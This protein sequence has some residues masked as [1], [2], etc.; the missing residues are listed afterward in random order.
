MATLASLVVKLIT[1]AGGFNKGLGEAE[2][3][4][5]SFTGGIQKNLKSIGTLA[6][7]AGGLIAA[8]LGG[9]LVTL[10]PQA[11]NAASDFQESLSKVQV[12]FGDSGAAVE[13]FSR[14]TAASMGI[15]QRDALAAAGTFGNLFRT[16]DIGEGASAQMSMDLVGL[17]ADLASFNNLDPTEVLDKLRSGLVGETEPLRSLGINLTDA[18][19]R[20]KAMELGLASSTK[21]VSQAA[22]TQARFALIMDQSALAQ[23][24]FARTS[25]GLANQQ[26]ILGATWQDILQKVGQV[27]LPLLNGALGG[28]LTLLQGS[29]IPAIDRVVQ[30]FTDFQWMLSVGVEPLSAFGM[31]LENLGVP[32]EVV[33]GIQGFVTG[34]QTL[35]T[36]VITAA[37]PI[38]AWIGQN[39]QLQDV[40]IAIGAAIAS[41][42]VPAIASIIAA[43]APVVATFVG[44]VAI[45]A[46]LRAAWESDFL[47]IQTALTAAWAVIQ[48]AL[49]ELWTW[50]QTNIPVALQTLS[51]FWTGTLLPAI[52]AVWDFLSANVIP[53]FAAIADV[54]VASI[55]LQLTALAGVWQNVFLPALQTVGG[56]IANTFGP[57]LSNLTTWL[58]NV[59]GGVDGVASAFQ[60]A[61]QWVQGMADKIKSLTLP[62][63]LTPGSP[64]PLEIGLLGIGEATRKLAQVEL[65]GLRA[66]FTGLRESQ[67]APT[68]SAP[69]TV[70]AQ[71]ASG[72]DVEDL[73]WRVSEI[74]GQRVAGYV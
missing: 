31:L 41:V 73:A 30:A 59:T 67:T 44:L 3:S 12:V 46:A 51:A 23:G 47:G 63:W 4:L 49:A 43:A 52:T 61:I 22:M 48:P 57:I 39:V 50:L 60:N 9:A 54:Y 20:T 6:L 38:V 21:E 28:F 40:L 16:M 26:R 35:I 71:V 19:V 13:D 72:I 70:N 14:T 7:G 10:G 2:K 5:G 53:L 36:Q 65:P 64:T 68:V 15:A 8:G 18:A 24:D 27:G 1:D 58:G 66:E 62:E 32:P 33:A 69:V 55:G 45:I 29:I 37:A 74:I 34:L 56:W 11:I 25:D 17:S 42:V